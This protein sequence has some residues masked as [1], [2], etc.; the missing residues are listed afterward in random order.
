MSCIL[1][2]KAAYESLLNHTAF[3]QE[4]EAANLDP[5]NV[6]ADLW[7]KN[8]QAFNDRYEGRYQDDVISCE[9][10]ESLDGEFVEYLHGQRSLGRLFDSINYQVA[11]AGDYLKGEKWAIYRRLK[12]HLGR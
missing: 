8:K 1:Y 3:R 7:E 6:V 10:S 5:A 4:C 12:A 9:T 2:N 11:D